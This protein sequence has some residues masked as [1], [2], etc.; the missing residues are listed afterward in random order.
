MLR[1]K[2][3]HTSYHHVHADDHGGL[4]NDDELMRMNPSLMTERQQLAFLLRK[5]AHDASSSDSSGESSSDDEDRAMAAKG[6]AGR[7]IPCT[8]ACCLCLF[9]C[10]RICVVAQW[11]TNML[12]TCLYCACLTANNN[13]SS[14][15]NTATT[16]QT[17]DV[18]IYCGRG[19]PPKN[20]IKLPPGQSS[21]EY[22]KLL[23]SPKSGALVRK[24][25]D[26]D[27]P[28]RKK[29]KVQTTTNFPLAAANAHGAIATGDKISPSS[30]SDILHMDTFIESDSKSSGV[31]TATTSGG[32][33]FWRLHCALCCDKTRAA[34][35]LDAFGSDALFLCPSCDQKYPT[36]RALGRV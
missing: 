8:F 4:A 35:A 7:R 6:V 25:E 1:P 13:K 34:A 18:V 26:A 14:P 9:A 19:R 17:G 23:L 32:G 33:D 12:C 27:E 5:T 24:P 28:N 31:K 16:S 3:Q 36:Q 10:L 15:R 2:R 30:S 22:K 29:L 21:D 20:S 11:L